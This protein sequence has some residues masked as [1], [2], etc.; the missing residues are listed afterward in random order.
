MLP[1]RF[2][3]ADRFVEEEFG[4][5]LIR[6][7]GIRRKNELRLERWMMVVNDVEIGGVEWENV[8]RER[9]VRAPRKPKALYASKLPINCL[10]FCRACGLLYYT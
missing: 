4:T 3:R 5:L 10:L 7:L 8:L 2:F 6:E 9:R 1:H